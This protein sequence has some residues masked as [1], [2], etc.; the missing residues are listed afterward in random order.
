MSSEDI[1]ILENAKYIITEYKDK[2]GGME[3][4]NECLS[5]VYKHFKKVI[6][7]AKFSDKRILE[8][9]NL[10]RL[11][12]DKFLPLESEPIFNEDDEHFMPKYI[13]NEKDCE[14]LLDYIVY[15]ARFELNKR[16]DLKTDP[17]EKRCIESSINVINICNKLGIKQN[18]YGCAFD[19]SPGVFHEFNIVSIALPDGTTKNYLVDCTYRQFFTFASSHLERIGMPLNSGAN[20]GAYMMMDES[21]KRFA[22]ELLT[23]G[24]VEFNEEN[25]KHYFDGFVFA[26]RNGLYYESLNKTVIEKQDYEPSYSASDY[27]YAL[28]NGG[29]KEEKFIG[30]QFSVLHNEIDFGTIDNL[31][32]RGSIKY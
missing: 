23:K 3:V 4:I 18:S 11:L 15:R 8:V 26:G 19:L 24:Y 14:N 16:Y 17:L 29:L 28:N 25:I 31:P 20:I 27:I 32:N 12:S 22:E 13:N 2:P 5:N 1:K 6:P 30:R 9:F 7:E 21:R 10:E